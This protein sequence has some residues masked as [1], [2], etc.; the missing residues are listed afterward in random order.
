MDN[1]R[2]ISHSIRRFAEGTMISRIFGMLR[3]ISL[4]F[5]FGATVEIAAFMVAFRLASVFRRLFGEALVGSIFVPYFEEIRSQD[6]KKASYFYR[7]LSFSLLL[8]LSVLVSSVLCIGLFFSGEI[9]QYTMIMLVGLIFICLT[10][11]NSSYLQCEKRYFLPAISPI[12]FNVVTLIAICSIKE[13]IGY[14]LSI[15]VVIGFFMQWLLTQVKTSR[16]LKMSPREWFTP[17]FFPKE[18][19]S[20][21]KPF[22]LG[23]MGI[24]AVQINSALDAIFARFADPI[25]PSYLWYAI[26]LQ[27]LPMAL[28]AVSIAAS[29][30]PPLARAKDNK[31]SFDGILSD[32]LQKGAFLMTFCTFGI[33]ALGAPSLNL[34]FGHGNFSSQSLLISSGCLKAYSLAL[35]P[36]VFV[37]IFTQSLS[38]RKNFLVPATA[39]VYA[40]L[41]NISLNAFFVFWMGMGIYSIAIAT[42]ISALFNA[43][44][45]GIRFKKQF[46]KSFFLLFLKVVI[47][48]SISTYL[49]LSTG[50]VF[51]PA[52]VFPRELIAQGTE[53]IILSF[54]YFSSFYIQCR[55]FKI[56]NL[57]KGTSD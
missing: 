16:L 49:T 1:Q 57:F 34:L 2:S 42:S 25:G 36:S 19:R 24:G 38:A 9:V 50:K 33:W 39:S 23:V 20:L 52:G 15:S 14:F 43:I 8:F 3:D 45:L 51:H 26:R 35:I 10:A 37:F 55:L 22:F 6:S 47:C 56:P 12:L 29:I 48:G 7:D 53:F 17:Q 13:R 11:V 46:D 44:I 4:A 27:Q 40:V 18:I 5:F 54:V 28:F 30:L 21:L 41:C 31:I 32:A